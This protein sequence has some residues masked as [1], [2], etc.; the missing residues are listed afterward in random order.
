MRNSS[1]NV[2]A[3]WCVLRHIENATIKKKLEKG[4]K[5]LQYGTAYGQLRSLQMF[6][7]SQGAVL[8]WG[9]H[10]LALPLLG[11]SDEDGIFC[12][13]LQKG[14]SWGCPSNFTITSLGTLP[15]HELWAPWPYMT[16]R[17]IHGSLNSMTDVLI[18]L[19]VSH[20]TLPIHRLL[21]CHYLTQQSE[22]NEQ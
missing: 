11:H 5:K 1:D 14:L 22:F 15:S 19:N 8:A 10:S 7:Q 2:H 13:L 6:K 18:I 17:P 21:S 3:E 12:F 4:K 9:M 20:I 16:N